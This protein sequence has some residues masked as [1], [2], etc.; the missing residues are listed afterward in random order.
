MG[1]FV[2]FPF[3]LFQVVT[4]LNNKHYRQLHVASDSDALWKP[5]SIATMGTTF[6][7]SLT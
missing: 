2:A 4:S 6:M 1:E 3:A 7:T 5:H